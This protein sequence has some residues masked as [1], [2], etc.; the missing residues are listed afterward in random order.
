MPHLHVMAM[1]VF[2]MGT[3]VQIGQCVGARNEKKAAEAV[4]IVEKLIGFMFL[5]PSAFLCI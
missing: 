2:V 3:T 1:L 5:V 4:G